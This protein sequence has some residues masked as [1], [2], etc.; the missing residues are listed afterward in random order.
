MTTDMDMGT[1][2]DIDMDM[3]M[4]PNRHACE[5]IAHQ[6][7]HSPVAAERIVYCGNS[8]G[9]TAGQDGRGRAA[10]TRK[11]GHGS[12]DR[13]AGNGTARAGIFY[14]FYGHRENRRSD[15]KYSMWW[16]PFV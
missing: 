12:R 5:E 16:T 7:R 8:Q 13:T 4:N 14:S 3:K 1:G 11:L 10:G 2:I 15:Q 9:R 6:C